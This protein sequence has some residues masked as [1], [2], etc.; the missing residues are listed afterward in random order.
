MI[1]LP[2]SDEIS[3]GMRHVAATL[4]PRSAAIGIALAQYV[5]DGIV[6]FDRDVVDD[7]IQASCQSSTAS[8]FN[9]LARGIP[10]EAVMPTDEVLQ[11]TR[12][13][14]QRGM[15]LP[16]IMRG[17]RVGMRFLLETWA[18][19]VAVSGLKD[20]LAIDVIK[21]GSSYMLAWADLINERIS[22]EYQ[23]LMQDKSIT[24]LADVRRVLDNP[25][26]DAKIASD[27]QGYPLTGTHLAF[28][29]RLSSER[30]DSTAAL[31]AEASQL[32]RGFKADQQLIARADL[33]TL[34]CWLR[35]T[36][37]VPPSLP[38]L[39]PSGL[40]AVGR[41]GRGIEGF[42]TSHKD[43][44]AALQV[45]ELAGGGSHALIHFEQVEVA[46]LCTAQPER[47]TDFVRTQLGDLALDDPTMSLQRETLAAF[48]TAN[49]NYRATAT[50]LG[51]HHNTVRYRLEQAEQ[52][53]GRS[54]AARPLGLE[55]A[56]YLFVTLGL[57]PIR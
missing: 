13:M 43:A 3:G 46:A 28:V 53:L 12:H 39:T 48:Y 8:L 38:A 49:C 52:T 37:H 32:L 18:E 33:R 30:I 7:G 55:L 25:K 35:F 56:L 23:R 40:V 41:P 31:E 20:A 11:L 50:M 5:H 9:Y 24:L 4:L 6:D 44:L 34:W 54:V 26:L 36:R 19:Q 16:A 21:A 27:L 51:I 2:V 15:D 47:C 10:V 42:R 57:P 1:T 17:Y 22:C 29:W 45:S 14:V